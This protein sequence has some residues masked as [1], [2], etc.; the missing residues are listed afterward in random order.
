M[1]ALADI[2]P[3]RTAREYLLRLITDTTVNDADFRKLLLA[4]PHAALGKFFGTPPPTDKYEFQ[5]LEE[6]ATTFY[7][8]VPEIGLLTEVASPPTI[9]PRPRFEGRLHAILREDPA[10]LPQF[11]ERPRAFIA[12]WL[13]FRL[14]GYLDVRPLVERHHEHEDGGLVYVVLKH[15]PHD[16]LFLEPY[17]LHFG[18][19][20]SRVTVKPSPSLDTPEAMSVEAWLRVAPMLEPLGSGS[21]EVSGVSRRGEGLGWELSIVEGARPRFT[22]SIGGAQHSVQ[23]QATNPPLAP[24]RWYYLAG[25]F[26][27][28]ELQL[29]ID[30]LQ[31]AAAAVAGELDVYPGPLL[32]G[33]NSGLRTGGRG[34]QGEIDEVL[35]WRRALQRAEIRRKLPRGA[36]RASQTGELAGLLLHFPCNEGNGDVVHDSS[37][38][39][40]DGALEGVAW[41]PQG[42]GRP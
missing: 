31:V 41:L 40:H 1:R 30:G 15:A 2:I 42:A 34:F 18:K 32:I 10:L 3:P 20:T 4:E 12:E 19:P 22:V 36:R 26:T 21:A 24:G 25:V 7:F 6:D 35:L 39:G 13:N 16:G 37:R 11:E 17:S 9:T 5:A 28:G 29:W 38:F 33:D 27:G 23:L 8:V 14:P